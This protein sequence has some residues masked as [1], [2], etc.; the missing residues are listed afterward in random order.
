MCCQSQIA[1]AR[2]GKSRV[3]STAAAMDTQPPPSQLDPHNASVSSTIFFVQ[4]LQA[5]L[6]S[7]HLCCQSQIAAARKGKSI[8]SSIDVGA[9]KTLGLKTGVATRTRNKDLQ[10]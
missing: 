1:V 2:K 6:T 4:F 5:Y 7:D 9:K 10:K 8:M 3:T